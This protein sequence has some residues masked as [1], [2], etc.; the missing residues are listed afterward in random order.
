MFDWIRTIIKLALLIGG[1]VFIY[2]M[3]SSVIKHTNDSIKADRDG[4]ASATVVKSYVSSTPFGPATQLVK[5][6]SQIFYNQNESCFVRTTWRWVLHLS[7]GK[8]VMWNKS[9][10]EFYAGD[11]NEDLAQAVMVP[12][13]LIP[14]KYTLSRLAVFKC[15]DVDDFARI[16]RNT[17][18][19]VE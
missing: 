19:Q 6:D 5:R 17:D 12:S 11:K 9:D 16:V 8:A 15:G 3:L 18:L 14:G 7:Q 2:M 1:L 10:G 13:F 4:N